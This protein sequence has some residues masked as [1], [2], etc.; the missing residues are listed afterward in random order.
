MNSVKVF[1]PATVANVTC[2]FDIL[3]FALHEPGDTLTVRK[4]SKPGLKV[5]ESSHRRTGIPL[6]PLQNTAT[7]AISALLRAF[8]SQIGFEIEIEKGMPV[9]SGLGSSAASAAG[10]VYAANL[11]LGE[12]FTR[13][14]LVSFAMEGEAAACGTAHADNVAPAL[15][16]GFAL[17][18]SYH[19]LD[20]VPIP[21][22]DSLCVAIV[23]PHIEVR[24]EDSRRVVKKNISLKKAVMQFGNIAGLIA[25]LSSGDTSLIGRSLQDHI[26]EPERSILIP[27]F[28]QAK[29]AALNAGALGFGI[30]GSG[31]AVFSLCSS[32]SA[33]QSV[34]LAMEKAFLTS[35]I[36]CSRYVSKINPQGVTIRD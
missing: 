17:L 8:D 6:D 4:Q 29:A 22:P 34:S 15:L 14:E 26:I 3:G 33:A 25:G 24:T 36:Q 23:A 31:P 28:Q 2:A 13:T 16:G 12:P 27:G 35:D 11:L 21:Y 19:P 7:V 20:I 18:R 9:G 32:E 5:L 10:G 30:S 1:A